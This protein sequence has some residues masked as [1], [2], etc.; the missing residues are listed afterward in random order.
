MRTVYEASEK[1]E[2]VTPFQA[3]Y[4][5]QCLITISARHPVADGQTGPGGGGAAA[6]LVS[7]RDPD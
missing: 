5:N 1:L 2:N 4:S 6:E 7:H 3:H